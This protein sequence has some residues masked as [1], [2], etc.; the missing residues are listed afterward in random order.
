MTT[1]MLRKLIQDNRGNAMVEFGLILP[2]LTVMA[3][4]A[5]DFGRLFI[6]SAILAG[7]SKSGAVQGYRTTRD[8]TDIAAMESRILSDVG[9]LPGV[10][11]KGETFCDCPDNPGVAVSCTTTTCAGYGLPRVYVKATAAKK[12]STLGRYPGIP[13]EVD[14]SVK[15][16]LRVQ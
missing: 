6:E 13:N 11:A 15:S 3:F 8:S 10:T 12:L 5:A 1:S 7:A 14:M 16:Y 2:V 4:G 9:E